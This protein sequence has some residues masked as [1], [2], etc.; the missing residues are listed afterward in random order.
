MAFLK[1]SVVLLALCVLIA[2]CRSPG[3][4]SEEA[5]VKRSVVGTG[6]KGAILGGLVGAIIPG[7]SWKQGAAA[8]GAL[9]AGAGLFKRKK[10]DNASPSNID[11]TRTIEADSNPG[12]SRGLSGLMNKFNI[13]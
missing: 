9:G 12:S 2:E 3:G 11:N 10:H 6:V 7:V 13:G 1:T 5:R 8:G 4:P